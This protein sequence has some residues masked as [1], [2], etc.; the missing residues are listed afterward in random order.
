M[1]QWQ[2]SLV[3]AGWDWE[4]VVKAMAG[5]SASGGGRG[6]TPL[7][8]VRAYWEGL[9]Q[10]EAP[11]RRETIDPRGMAGAL[12]H[13][14]LLERI[15]H[16]IGRFRLA[17]NHLALLMGMEV[18]GMP[19]TALFEPHARGAIESMLEETLSTPAIVE[20]ALE[21]ERG[22]GRPALEGRMLLLPVVGDTGACDR[23]LGCLVTLGQIGRSPRRFAIAR[24][25]TSALA[26][27]QTDPA[28]TVIQAQGFAEATED[29]VQAPIR[30]GQRARG[31]LRLVASDD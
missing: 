19:L 3:M 4:Q 26:A 27:K 16:G 15:G 18:R 25:R 5:G 11:P 21:A 24:Q 10:R 8:E 13:V 6:Y 2:E 31:H 20:I 1:G 22:I 29:F 12:E 14:F 30:R 23:V 9:R 7:Q 28:S 17:G